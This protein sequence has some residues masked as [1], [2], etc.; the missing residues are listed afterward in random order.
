MRTS[1][2]DAN[3]GLDLTVGARERIVTLARVVH[4]QRCVSHI[5]HVRD[6]SAVVKARRVK[7]RIEIGSTS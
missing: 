2:I 5:G 3:I 6:T 4:R 7:T 1:G